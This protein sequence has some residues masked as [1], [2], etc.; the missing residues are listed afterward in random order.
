MSRYRPISNMSK[1]RI[2]NIFH[3]VIR[4]M[5]KSQFLV[6]SRDFLHATINHRRT[7]NNRRPM[8]LVF[9]EES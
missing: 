6:F 2:D 7:M 5:F 4:K 8:S 3:G 9:T 1:E